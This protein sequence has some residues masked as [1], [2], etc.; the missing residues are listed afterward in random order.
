MSDPVR[1][2]LDR[3]ELCEL[4]NHYAAAMNLH[5]W[6]RLRAV[7]AAGQIEADFTSM[8]VRQIFRGPADEWVEGAEQPAR[9]GL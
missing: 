6:A 4:M 1:A 8:G 2:L 5:D 9:G 7:F 3:Q